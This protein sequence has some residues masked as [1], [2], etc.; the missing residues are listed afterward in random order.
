VTWFEENALELIRAHA[1]VLVKA[2]LEARRDRRAAEVRA[3]GGSCTRFP[4]HRSPQRAA[5]QDRGPERRSVRARFSPR[6]LFSS[7]A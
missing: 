1:D 7:V 5:R 4:S 6:P 3:R 2:R